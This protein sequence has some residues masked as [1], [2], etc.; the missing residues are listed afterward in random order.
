MIECKAKEKRKRDGE[1]MTKRKNLK[2]YDKQRDAV[3]TYRA[4]KKQKPIGTTF[5]EAE[6]NYIK[7]VYKA[8]GVTVGEVIRGAAAALR[9]G[10]QI[11]TEREP[12]PTEGNAQSTATDENQNPN[13]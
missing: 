6:T 13:A 11:R 2:T 7:S 3:E 12:L 1:K 10:Q 8:H 9:D 4:K 5:A